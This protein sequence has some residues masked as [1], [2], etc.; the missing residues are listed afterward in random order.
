MAFADKKKKLDYLIEL[1]KSGKTGNTDKLAKRICVSRRT[2]FRYLDILRDMD[3]QIV[4]C[5]RSESYHLID[6]SEL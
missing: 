5:S 6:T 2:L 3:Y 4:Y 1:I